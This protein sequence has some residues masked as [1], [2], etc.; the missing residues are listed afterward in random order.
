MK[1]LFIAL[2]ACLP[3]FSQ[4]GTVSFTP[5]APGHVHMQAGTI[6]CDLTGNAVP[7]TVITVSCDLDGTPISY[8]IPVVEGKAYTTQFNSG[9]VGGSTG[10]A[11]SFS[12]MRAV[13]GFINWQAAA[14]PNGGQTASGSG[15]F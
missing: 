15:N 5:P 7:A 3:A 1:I 12:F 11:V 6:T 9:V 4:T 2:L 13:G 10:D 14:T 8:N